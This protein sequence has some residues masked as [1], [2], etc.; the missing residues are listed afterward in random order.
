MIV[1]LSNMGMGIW[2]CQTMASR[3]KWIYCMH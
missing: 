3:T 1:T 2:K